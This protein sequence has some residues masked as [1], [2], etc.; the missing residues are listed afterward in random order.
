LVIHILAFG[1]VIGAKLLQSLKDLLLVRPVAVGAQCVPS[2][3]YSSHFKIQFFEKSKFSIQLKSDKWSTFW[4]PDFMLIPYMTFIVVKNWNSMQKNPI[5]FP[6]KVAAFSRKISFRLVQYRA[7]GYLYL[8]KLGTDVPPG[9]L[10][11]HAK[12]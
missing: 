1:A 11:Y 4:G 3:D 9:D 2:V 5:C 10:R 12:S 7:R 6:L 8:L